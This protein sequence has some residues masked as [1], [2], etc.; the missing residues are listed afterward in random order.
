ME[1]LATIFLFP[2]RF[3]P[4]LNPPMSGPGKETRDAE[5]K[6]TASTTNL[7]VSRP[8]WIQKVLGAWNRLDTETM[9][10]IQR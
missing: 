6:A 10:G 9:Q 2:I 1:I 8:N 3:V 7:L 5:W 4:G